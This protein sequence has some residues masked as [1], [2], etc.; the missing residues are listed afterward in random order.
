MEHPSINNDSA[1]I[2]ITRRLRGYSRAELARWS[3]VPPRRLAD[4]ES[5]STPRP[6]ELAALWSV[7][8]SS[9]PQL[10]GSKADAD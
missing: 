2:V 10:E 8:M 4:I 5:G 1:A 6:A 3:R 9:T 7:L